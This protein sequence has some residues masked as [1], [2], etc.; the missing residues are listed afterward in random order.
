MEQE[1]KKQDPDFDQMIDLVLC[2][3]R[4]YEAFP[5]IYL[6]TFSMLI[7]IQFYRMCHSKEENSK[8]VG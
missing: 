5:T 7:W 6:D 8:W 2:F 1:D 4:A 3:N